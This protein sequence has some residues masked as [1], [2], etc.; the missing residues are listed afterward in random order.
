MAT[1]AEDQTEKYAGMIEAFEC[2]F[3]L[4]L[5]EENGHSLDGLQLKIDQN[6]ERML[7]DIELLQELSYGIR[8]GSIKIIEQTLVNEV[9]RLG[10]T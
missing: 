7:S 1:H 4:A 2:D 9:P 5:D 8:H 10:S 6:D 3:N